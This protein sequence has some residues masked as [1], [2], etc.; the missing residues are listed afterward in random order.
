VLN[1]CGVAEEQLWPYTEARVAERPPEP[2]Y[3]NAEQ[4]QC[5]SYRRLARSLT[6]AKSCLAVGFPFAL[7]FSIYEHVEG[8]E[9]AQTGLVRLP[10]RGEPLIGGHA[11]LAVGYDDAFVS[12]P[13]EG[14]GC[15]IVRNSW[16]DTWGDAGHLYLPY[17]YFLNRRLSSD[18]WTI[19]Q[20][21]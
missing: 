17:Q 10:A 3:Q 4:H 14:P 18:F 16:G 13:K 1:K 9:V 2:V 20:V 11:V 19:R 6:A 7:G 8:P 15:F 5:L 21:E 12:D